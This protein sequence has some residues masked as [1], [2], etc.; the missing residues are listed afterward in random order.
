MALISSESITL[1]VNGTLQSEFF[2]MFCPIRFTYSSTTGS[3]ISFELFSTSSAYCFPILISPSVENQ[4]PIPRLPMSRL[5]TA[6]TSSMLPALI[7]IIW[8]P[9]SITLFTSTGPAQSPP[10]G[11]VPG[12]GSSTLSSLSFFLSFLSSLFFVSHGGSCALLSADADPVEVVLAAGAGAS[13]PAGVA[14]GAGCAVVYVVDPAAGLVSAGA[15]AG[16][17]AVAG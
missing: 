12:S 9:G 14:P 15:V 6:F 11:V 10:T 7:G 1:I 4:L 13:P 8:L 2:T 3:V 17:C 16:A 5:P